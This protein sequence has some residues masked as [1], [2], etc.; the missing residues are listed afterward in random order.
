[1]H[2]RLW[3][4]IVCAGCGS[5]NTAPNDSEPADTVPGDVGLAHDGPPGLPACANPVAGS[6]ISLRK[7]GTV[8]VGDIATLATSPPNDPRLFVLAVDGKIRIF[9]DEVLVATP[10]LDLSPGAGG[11]VSSGDEMGLLGLAFHPLYATNG[12]FYIYYTTGDPLNNTLRD[13][14]A[15]CSVSPNN[16][17]HADASSCVEILAVADPASN[18]NG[19]MMEFGSDGL[20]YIGT[21]DG[22]GTGGRLTSQ[23]PTLLFG[24]MLRIDVDHKTPGAEYGTPADNPFAAGG[25]APEV[26][27][28]GLRNP[29]R[30][31][32]DRETGDMWIGDVGASTIEELDVLRPSQQRGANLGWS[33]YEGSQCFTAPCD[34]A[35]KVFPKDERLHSANWH[36]IIGGQVY[37]GT[38]YPDLVGWYFYTDEV[39]RV[40]IKAR[41]KPDDTLEIVD[42]PGMIPQA[43]SLHADA[44]GELYT[45]D[46]HG[47]VYHLEAAP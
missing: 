4:L 29:W 14:V 6:A 17:D 38:C 13:I 46:L 20:L 44:R 22:G 26:F 1:M 33:M 47:F 2:V 12:L 8:N 31:S 5:G 30:W 34:P 18:H 24:K 9:K 39:A 3:L 36:A 25:G 11:P 15:R 27:M 28:L 43:V 7:L 21:G 37:R 41:L 23:D 40:L 19:G 32:F 16:P 45:T 10:F 42:L 35:G